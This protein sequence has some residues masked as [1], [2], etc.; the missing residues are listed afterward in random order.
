MNNPRLAKRSETF[1]DDNGIRVDKRCFFLAVGDDDN[2]SNAFTMS[3]SIN[4]FD[5]PKI[6]R[7][8]EARTKLSNIIIELCPE[9][10][11][12]AT[13]LIPE[14]K[15]LFRF[16]DLYPN[17]AFNKRMIELMT[18]LYMF[19]E[20][21]FIHSK[22]VD[23]ELVLAAFLK[24][25]NQRAESRRNSIAPDQIEKMKQY[26]DVSTMRSL[27]SLDKALRDID[28]DV[29]FDT[30]NISLSITGNQYHTDLS[31]EKVIEVGLKD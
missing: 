28:F 6:Q 8:L 3:A 13:Q 9:I 20:R 1:D 17:K 31:N 25:V 14:F 10:L 29:Y 21:H 22:D 24:M 12:S 2:A 23:E 11:K 5:E 19:K 15:G 16:G 27:K 30:A 4:I 18:P 26:K 7:K